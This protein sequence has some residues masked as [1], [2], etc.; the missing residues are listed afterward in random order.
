MVL[1]AVGA[2]AK[3]IKNEADEVAALTAAMIADYQARF[4]TTVQ[5]LLQLAQSYPLA[6]GFAADFAF[7]ALRSKAEKLCP[8]CA[9]SAHSS[10]TPHPSPFTLTLTIHP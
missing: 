5:R 7:A 3:S 4:H 6:C 9:S 8:K 10:P 1:A 2:L